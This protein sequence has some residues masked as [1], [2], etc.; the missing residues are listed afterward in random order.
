[1]AYAAGR[2]V[3]VTPVGGLVGAVQSGV[4]GVVAA[5]ASADALADAIAEAWH[6]LETLAA[7]AAAAVASWSDVVAAV[8]EAADR[9][10]DTT[11]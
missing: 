4:S 9:S 10:T 2:G 6:D 1:M 3:V 11:R 5:A 7:G 8:L